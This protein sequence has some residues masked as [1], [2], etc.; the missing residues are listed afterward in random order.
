MTN[1]TNDINANPET[2]LMYGQSVHQW[3]S[4]LHDLQQAVMVTLPYSFGTLIEFH[5]GIRSAQRRA[6][7]L[8]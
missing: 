5:T 4:G 3:A 1:I 7:Q 6:D 2:K 8:M